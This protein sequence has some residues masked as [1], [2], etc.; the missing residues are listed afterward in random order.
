[1]VCIFVQDNKVHY[2][3]LLINA[4]DRSWCARRLR[5]HSLMFNLAI[6]LVLFIQVQRTHRAILAF[7]DD[8]VLLAESPEKLQEMIQATTDEL[9]LL[10]LHLNPA[11]CATL[12]IKGDT[13]IHAA[14]TKF[15]L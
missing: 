11:K 6:D 8:L 10:F 1:M 4:S 9:G 3:V 7:A 2:E 14:P 5:A 12:H 15:T 13:P